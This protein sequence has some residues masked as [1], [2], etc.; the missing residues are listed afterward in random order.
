MKEENEK[1]RQEK[2]LIKLEYEKYKSENEIIK[3]ENEKIKE[4]IRI[5][6]KENEIIKLEIEN[7]AN[8]NEIVK[9]ENNELNKKSEDIEKEIRNEREE[10]NLVLDYINKIFENNDPLKLFSKPTLIGLKNIGTGSY[11]NPV[12]QCFSQTKFLTNYFLRKSFKDKKN[13]IEIKND[14]SVQLYQLY[15][16]LIEKL[17]NINGLKSFSPENF[18]NN[19]EKM[20]PIFR[21]NQNVS[22]KDFIIFF[23]TQMHKELAKPNISYNNNSNLKYIQYSF[24]QYNK[25]IILE[26]FFN[27]FN[28][29][30]SIISDYFFGFTETSIECLNCK[31][32]YNFN[33]GIFNCII[34]KLEEINNR[35]KFDN[36]QYNSLNNHISLNDYFFYK[37]ELLCQNQKFQNFCQNCNKF[38]DSKFSS[39]IFLSPNILIIIIER[40]KYNKT[41]IK[42]DFTETIDI[43]E[44]VLKKEISKLIYNLYAVITSKNNGN[45][46]N[47]VAS[48]KSPIDKKWYRY[49]DEKVYPINN[50]EKEV[51]E[52]GTPQI[53]FYEKINL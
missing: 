17:W 11:I 3:Q 14:N 9:Q 12:L 28:Q 29:E 40:E 21:N 1:N 18:K 20:N 53:L 50:L 4:E 31:N 48:C 43:T 24:N 32:N 42:L 25:N 47:F 5:I 37:K 52:F 13:N 33:Y 19:I 46:I 38:C 22:S 44:F 41:P 36:L 45:S 39:K 15:I 34:F 16:E 10:Y 23:L 7:N 35:K 8:K 51:I 6:K 30:C 2:E 27:G 26:N 49:D